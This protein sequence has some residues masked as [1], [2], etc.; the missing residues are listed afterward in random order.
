MNYFLKVGAAV[1]VG[2]L[3]SGEVH[4]ASIT[5]DLETSG[6]VRDIDGVS[7][8]PLLD[9]ERLEVYKEGSFITSTFLEVSLSRFTS[10]DLLS[11]ATLSYT[12]FPTT[13]SVSA[14]GYIG[15]GTA[16]VSDARPSSE[17]LGTS[18]FTVGNGSMNLDIG[19][20][21]NLIASDVDFLGVTLVANE[22]TELGG[23]FNAAISFEV[24]QGDTT[25][26]PVP[27]SLPLLISGLGFLTLVFQRRKQ[28]V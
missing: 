28:S 11:T 7:L 10:G 22:D 8:G 4:A 27:A 16:E 26:V 12:R 25:V 23:F 2:I 6:R 9:T 20:I 18:A 14:F 24:K 5:P 19:Y 15:N 1:V 13:A 17:L 21:N 3:I